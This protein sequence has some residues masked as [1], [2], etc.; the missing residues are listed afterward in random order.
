MSDKIVD[1]VIV[2]D[3]VK[4]PPLEFEDEWEVI[5]ENEA[6]DT[7]AEQ[8]EVKP[9][10]SEEDIEKIIAERM[11]AHKPDDNSSELAGAL[12]D[13]RNALAPKAE[14]PKGR[15]WEKF[16]AEI[17]DKLSDD[18]KEAL[19]QWRTA[20]NEEIGQAMSYLQQQNVESQ[21]TISKLTA[22]NDPSLKVVFDRWSD[23][24]EEKAKTYTP[25]PGQTASDVYRKI[26]QEVKSEHFD[27]I[28]EMKIQEALAN[29]RK[30]A[31]LP[32]KGVVKDGDGQVI[33]GQRKKVRYVATPEQQK[34]IE[35]SINPQ[36]M[37][38]KLIREGKLRK[39]S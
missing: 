15:D 35:R 19:K 23:E 30:D 17:A 1:E 7:E 2:E 16:E 31:T 24:I 4:K 3:E 36:I 9:S 14:Q 28:L 5:S 29:Q 10:T 21:K 39:I 32:P 12:R 37:R 8:V 26:A 25:Q 38:E 18:P 22:Q 13:I 33:E 20:Y 34:M 11:A 6:V 27:D